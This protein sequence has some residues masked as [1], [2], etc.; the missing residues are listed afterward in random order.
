M[1]TY[2][3]ARRLAERGHQVHVV[4]NAKEVCAPFRM[5]MRPEDWKQCDGKFG[6]VLKA[7]G[8]ELPAAESAKQLSAA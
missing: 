3:T 6:V 7:L 5:H 2:W 1:R 4:T 8:P